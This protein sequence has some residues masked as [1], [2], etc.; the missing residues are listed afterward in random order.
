MSASKGENSGI[1]KI[2]KGYA[3]RVVLVVRTL[4]LTPLAALAL[5]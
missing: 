5:L 4:A 3:N 2:R 1:Q